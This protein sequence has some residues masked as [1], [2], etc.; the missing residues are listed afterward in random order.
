MRRLSFHTPLSGIAGKPLVPSGVHA[1]NRCPAAA[2]DERIAARRLL[3]VVV[4]K[5]IFVAIWFWAG[6]YSSI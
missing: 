4:D 2:L 6:Q 3:G 1:G 5:V